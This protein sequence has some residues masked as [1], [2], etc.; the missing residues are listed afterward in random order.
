MSDDNL[1]A[2]TE[3][4][5]KY[6]A[7]IS[8]SSK[9][10]S[11]AKWLHSAL[12]T[13]RLPVR[14]IKHP[15]PAGELAPARL[16]PIFWDRAELEAHNSLGELI[17]RSL[18]SSR[19]LIVVCSPNAAQ[20]PWVEKEIRT[21]RGMHGTSR[22]LSI[23]VGGEPTAKD[24]SNCFPPS[25]RSREPKA[26]DARKQGDGKT[27]A[28]LML[29]ASMLGVSFDT[30]KQRDQERKVRSLAYSLV[31]ALAVS[32][33]MGWLA[34]KMAEARSS[35]V[36]AK[37][38]AEDARNLAVVSLVEAARKA[39]GNARDSFD[40]RHDP[41]SGF[42]N[43][44]E[45]LRYNDSLP[46]EAQ[47]SDITSDT[48]LRL[49]GE[50]NADPVPLTNL[51]RHEGRLH[52][53]RF[54]PD[55]SRI[56]TAS[57]DKT[58]RVWN[59]FTGTQLTPPL[60]H[61]DEVFVALFSPN[62]QRIVTASSD[63]SAR[64]WDANS[65][66]PV[67]L[68][69]WCGERIWDVKFS[70]DGKRIVTASKDCTARIWD[71]VTG[72]PLTEPM[73]HE[74]DVIAVVFSPDGELIISASFDSTARIWDSVTGQPI[75]EPIRHDGIVRCV[76]FSADGQ[77]VA[78]GSYDTTARVWDAFTG[79][80]SGDPMRHGYDVNDVHFSPDGQSIVTASSDK[81]AR[82]WDVA[83]GKPVGEIMRH[84]KGVSRAAYSADGLRVV[85]ASFDN[86]SRIW[87]S[88]TGLP[89]GE[90]LRH[91]MGVTDVCFSPDDL[92][93]VTACTDGTARLWN[94]LLLNPKGQPIRQEHP[95]GEVQFSP[96]GTRVI[97]RVLSNSLQMWDAT[98]CKPV[99]RR[100]TH[101]GFI[102]D[103]TYS[104]HGKSIITAS[105]DMTARLWGAG[106]GVPMFDPI[107]HPG[108]VN[109]ARFSPDG[110]YIVTACDDKNAR[111]WDSHNGKQV[112]KAMRHQKAVSEVNFA[113]DGK[114]VMTISLDRTV[115]LWDTK[116][117]SPIGVP[118]MHGDDVSDAA[119]SASGLLLVTASGSNVRLWSAVTG[120]PKG[121]LMKHESKVSDVSFGGGE[122]Q[123][124]VKCD[125]M[126][127]HY[128]SAETGTHLSSAQYNRGGFRRTYSL[129]QSAGPEDDSR[130]PSRFTLLS[131][132][133]VPTVK[134]NADDLEVWAGR[135]INS[136]GQ[137]EDIPQEKRCEWR[138]RLLSEAVAGDDPWRE[139]LKWKLTSPLS[140]TVTYYSKTRL[141]EHVERE[142]TWAFAH[143]ASTRKEP[144]RGVSSHRVLWDAYHLDPTHPLIHVALASLEQNSIRRDFLK[145][146]GVNNLLNNKREPVATSQIAVITYQAKTA[147]M[148]YLQGD[149][150]R[151][152]RVYAAFIADHDPKHET[153][154]SRDWIERLDDDE[155]PEAFKRSLLSMN[156]FHVPSESVLLAKVQKEVDP[157]FYEVDPSAVAMSEG[158]EARKC[159]TEKDYA[160]AVRHQRRAVKIHA[161]LKDNG[162]QVKIAYA[163]LA[164]FLL[165]EKEY[166][167][168]EIAAKSGLEEDFSVE[169]SLN[170]AHALLFQGRSEEAKRV[171]VK[172]QDFTVQDRPFFV[173][174]EE[175]FKAMAEAGLQSSEM[176]SV[177][178]LIEKCG[179]GVVVEVVGEPPSLR[180]KDVEPGLSAANAGVSVGTLIRRVDGILV[181]ST[182]L[183]DCSEMI[184]GPIDTTVELEVSD[185]NG[186][187]IRKISLKR[188][189]L[190]PRG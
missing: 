115:R 145:D 82:L 54:S 153:W 79:K 108:L 118:M 127:A 85:T 23:I 94:S 52:M 64:I 188:M 27:N 73:H 130:I 37:V 132:L 24:I 148:L 41:R 186:S 18:R 180:V 98:T 57:Q 59:A 11:W 21:F 12:E 134:V 50:P 76:S 55:G 38:K 2:E 135:K 161:S 141:P 160:G 30:L 116:D 84:D 97:S 80:P 63:H 111:L 175:D 163:N 6:W 164:W 110:K 67:G 151:A 181:S 86:T 70:P 165:F 88:V 90:P 5:N 122:T 107:E 101:G 17:E 8:Y 93:V 182:T 184:I 171:Y 155:W 83:T 133:A 40:S 53:A 100:L 58:A 28:K 179:I 112:A 60:K 92:N 120:R 154:A 71:A 75:G 81:T 65:G 51:I 14:L 46:K 87:D 19:Y 121:E 167:A 91:P 177:I 113:P 104:P 143:L 20:S 162:E 16:M 74:A 150:I 32:G 106:D 190:P 170:L 136:Y 77:R 4:V 159:F 140:R 157:A 61:D 22:I 158:D 34:W 176:S 174:V 166:S 146:Y 131:D 149:E 25:L 26:P 139:L 138:D 1:S 9:D 187:N 137:A 172:F 62:G 33:C 147:A 47:L 142:V 128:W 29:L 45:S 10:R 42:A 102:S 178:R 89:L 96:D 66:A 189:K 169:L 36:V 99:G 168:A 31:V 109:R 152:S 185:A 114:K 95:I 7:F 117:G 48:I 78:T 3:P 183:E 43:L 13:Y 68:P 15:T 173:V 123:I 103:I 105:L 156:G 124:V 44:A 125:D 126:T 69:I 119:F 72:K 49:F 144:F 129:I 35:E 39:Q 56:V